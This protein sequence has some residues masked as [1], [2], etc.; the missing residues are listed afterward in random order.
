MSG[1]WFGQ[2]YYTP[3]RDHPSNSWL[4][5]LIFTTSATVSLSDVSQLNRGAVLLI[6]FPFTDLTSSKLRPAIL[7]TD[8]GRI[9]GS[10]GH[11]VFL[12]TQHPPP[13]VTSIPVQ[14]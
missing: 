9:K 12:G 11:F 4:M 6:H 8:A 2:E 3:P 7:L 13:D 10:D 5:S 1:R 14:K